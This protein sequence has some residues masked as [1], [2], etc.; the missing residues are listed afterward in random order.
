MDFYPPPRRYKKR[1]RRRNRRRSRSMVALRQE[2]MSQITD[3]AT[4]NREEDEDTAVQLNK[5]VVTISVENAWACAPS[6]AWI[7]MYF[8]LIGMV[9]L[10]LRFYPTPLF[11]SGASITAAS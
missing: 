5:K 1:S 11:N 4:T 3:T 8:L 2:R 6:I 7:V 9:A 10:S